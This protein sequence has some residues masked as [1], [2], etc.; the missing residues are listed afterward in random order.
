MKCAA[1]FCVM[2]ARMISDDHELRIRKSIKH[3]VG[4]YYSCIELRGGWLHALTFLFQL[5]SVLNRY[6]YTNKA[7]IVPDN[8]IDD[9]K[10]G[11]FSSAQHQFILN[12]YSLSKWLVSCANDTCATSFRIN[13]RMLVIF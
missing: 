13:K 4:Q 2:N 12:A 10:I 11:P 9:R 1:V 6:Y 3:E 7:K 5:V 8:V